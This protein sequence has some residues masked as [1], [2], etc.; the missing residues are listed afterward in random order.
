[1][2]GVVTNMDR[3]DQGDQHIHVQQEGHESSSRNALTMS[4]VTVAPFSRTGRRGMLLRSAPADGGRRAWRASSETILPT[5]W[6][7]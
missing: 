2:R 3:I 1:M 7:R 5:G 6:L 4:R